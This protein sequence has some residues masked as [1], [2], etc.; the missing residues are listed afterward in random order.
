MKGATA[1]SAPQARGSPSY[2]ESRLAH[3]GLDPTHAGAVH[4]RLERGHLERRPGSSHH[5][6]EQAPMDGA[7]E[8]AVLL[9]EIPEWALSERD[10]DGSRA[11]APEPRRE[12]GPGKGV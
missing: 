3:P 7:D 11:G 5:P 10:L 12:P 2:I 1:S 8:L 6:L 4:Q 9:E